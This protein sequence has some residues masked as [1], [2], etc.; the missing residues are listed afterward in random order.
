MNLFV[1]LVFCVMW[2]L[3][4]DLIVAMRSLV[5]TRIEQCVTR[6]EKQRDHLVNFK[7]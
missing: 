1:P 2:V 7:S 4:S 5:A 6:A 3:L